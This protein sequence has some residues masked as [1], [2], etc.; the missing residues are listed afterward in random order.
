ML[1]G[2]NRPVVAM[3]NGAEVTDGR[4]KVT[5]TVIVLEPQNPNPIFSEDF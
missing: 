4:A 1:G 3:A 5:Y 2:R